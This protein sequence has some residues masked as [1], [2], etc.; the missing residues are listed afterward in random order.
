MHVVAPQLQFHSRKRRA[1][2]FDGAV[3]L[4][5]QR[6][7][8]S[9]GVLSGPPKAIPAPPPNGNDAAP[10]SNEHYSMTEMQSSHGLVSIKDSSLRF[11]ESGTGDK[12]NTSSIK[13]RPSS[14][15][16][17]VPWWLQPRPVIPSSDNACYYC[18]RGRVQCENVACQRCDHSLCEMC[19]RLCDSCNATWCPCC[20]IIDYDSP[21]ERTLCFDC[22]EDACADGK[23]IATGNVHSA[24]LSFNTIDSDGDD[25]MLS[26]E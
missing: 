7:Q 12:F 3:V 16:D 9:E 1:F 19:T 22:F 11:A 4:K 20:T 10:H 14:P 26:W 5:R 2:G 13:E 6:V 24:Q 15:H 17:D 21:I 8:S 18:E 25:I 23:S